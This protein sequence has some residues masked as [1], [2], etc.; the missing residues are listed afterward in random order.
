MSARR[1]NRQAEVAALHAAAEKH[2]AAR[3]GHGRRWARAQCVRALVDNGRS[4]ADAEQLAGHMLAFAE[5][6]G[7]R[8]DA[9]A[10]SFALNAPRP[11]Q[12]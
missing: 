7:K 10:A 2:M 3:N 12:P 5:A 9:L 6:F 11:A 8:A 4:E 1:I